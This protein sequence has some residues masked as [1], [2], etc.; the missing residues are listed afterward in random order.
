VLGPEM[1][2]TG[3]VMGI[4]S[5]F[6]G[7]Y[8]KAQSAAGNPL[9]LPRAGERLR[10]FVSV[11]DVDK[12]AAANLARRLVDL[13]FEVLATTGT[14]AFLGSR[15]IP[16][17]RVLK[18]GEGRPSVVDRIID[19]DV[20]FVINTTAGKTEISDSYSIRRETLMHRIP[21]FTTLTGARAA[22]GAMEGARGPGPGVT[23]L[24]EYHRPAGG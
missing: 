16:S 12:P 10:A 6:Y 22:L 20:H 7:A 2:S 13:G 4:S 21:Y 15:G 19:G 11:R 18:V 14:A 8:W 9:P 5:D 1:K 24:Q 17:T 3:E 23:T